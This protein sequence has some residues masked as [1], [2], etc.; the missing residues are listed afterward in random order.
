MMVMVMISINKLHTF[1]V[2]PGADMRLIHVCTYIIYSTTNLLC[3]ST[4]GVR[5]LKNKQR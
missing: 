4:R 5:D 3:Y 2:T 1:S